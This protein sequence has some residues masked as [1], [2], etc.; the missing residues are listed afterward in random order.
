M[1]CQCI[2]VALGAFRVMLPSFWDYEHF[3]L[4][5]ICSC[6]GIDKI[7]TLFEGDAVD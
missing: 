1:V 7:C 2:C 4:E 5:G 6:Q 3:F